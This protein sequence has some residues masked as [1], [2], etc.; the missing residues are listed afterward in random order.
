M[1]LQFEHAWENGMAE[2]EEEKSAC[3]KKLRQLLYDV[4]HSTRACDNSE[5]VRN[6][7]LW[8]ALIVRLREC[9]DWRGK[10]SLRRLFCRYVSSITRETTSASRRMTHS[11]PT[12]SA[13]QS[14]KELR[15]I[16]LF[17][18]IKLFIAWLN[19]NELNGWVDRRRSLTNLLVERRRN[20]SSVRLQISLCDRSRNANSTANRADDTNVNSRQLIWPIYAILFTRKLS[21]LRF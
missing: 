19:L 10:T 14:D 6:V 3:K 12:F 9:F 7:Q 4:S 13:L 11:S 21:Y 8:N 16:L 15:Q 17:W 18:I 20:A 5:E 2:E 1:P